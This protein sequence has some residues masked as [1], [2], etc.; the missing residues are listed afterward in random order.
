MADYTNVNAENLQD[1][2]RRIE[3]LREGEVPKMVKVLEEL[4]EDGHARGILAI[5]KSC[6]SV[7]DA[8]VEF[9]KMFNDLIE[10]CQRY[11]DITK[12]VA[13]DLGYDV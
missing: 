9:V 6:A 4:E 2:F 11:A 10:S 7:K 12:A 5:E 8:A 13:E 1:L 3:S